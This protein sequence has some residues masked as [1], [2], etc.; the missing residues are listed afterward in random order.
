MED[1]A[2]LYPSWT[3]LYKATQG[4]FK[5]AELTI[6]A[7]G[8]QTGKSWFVQDAQLQMHLT[9]QRARA[10]KFVLVNDEDTSALVVDV[11][12]SVVDWL[13]KYQWDAETLKNVGWRFAKVKRDPEPRMNYLSLNTERVIVSPE[14]YS[15]MILQWAN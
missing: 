7:S 15:M 9:K 12:A 1:L 10:P 5:K 13:V 11:A 2:D 8:R 3:K 4:G 6:L 14:L